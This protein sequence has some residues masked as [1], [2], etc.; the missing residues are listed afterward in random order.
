MTENTQRLW[1]RR[2]P[3]QTAKPGMPREKLRWD[4]TNDKRAHDD[5]P[6]VLAHPAMPY[7]PYSRD[8]TLCLLVPGST[9][10]APRVVPGDA[11]TLVSYLSQYVD[12][13]GSKTVGKGDSAKDVQ[14]PKLIS[15]KV[16]KAAANNIHFPYPPLRNIV[17]SPVI[18]RDGSLLTEPGYHA[19]S[20]LFLHLGDDLPQVP[21]RPTDA[22]VEEA[23]TFLVHR[24][25][26]DFEFVERSD[27]AN[28]LGYLFTPLLR[29][30]VGGIT[31]VFFIKADNPGSGKSYLAK[32]GGVVFGI[33]RMPWPKDNEEEV[34]KQIT[35]VLHSSAEPYILIDNVPAGTLV[36]SPQLAELL[37]SDTWSDRPLG[38][39]RMVK[40][41]NNR[42]WVM[43]GNN[44]SMG[45]DVGRRSIPVRLTCSAPHPE[46]RDPEQFSVGDLLDWAAEHRGEVLHAMLVLASSWLA[47]GAKE[48]KATLA[49]F[50]RWA[51]V[52]SGFLNH[53]GV[54]GFLE[55]RTAIV[56]AQSTDAE[57][58]E[59]L[60]I[61][62]Y[63]VHGNNWL[64][65]AEIAN[66]ATFEDLLA[67]TGC[68]YLN[69]RTLGSE[70]RSHAGRWYGS[71]RILRK[72]DSHSKTARWCVEKN[73]GQSPRG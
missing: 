42:V 30:Y 61:A 27:L 36:K 17:T 37:T 12:T 63:G 6:E 70:L 26:G 55:H 56:T 57:A 54:E 65:A 64:G 25:L 71:Y 44:I 60:L 16:C 35:A 59:A 20:G 18:L 68:G 47:G 40:M 38:F 24:V 51:K 67:E 3:R 41:D 50:D 31:P 4:I 73:G 66:N 19:P 72:T 32:F 21:D 10:E 14:T 58:W 13:F 43:T 28:Y 15:E 53:I 52:T 45:G 34:R 1:G 8:H 2:K 5:M 9:G 49:C 62:W 11:A 22:E 23:R 48:G 33:A 39:S 46:D 69:A 29:E 7:R